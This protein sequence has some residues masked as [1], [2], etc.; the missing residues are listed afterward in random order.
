MRELDL[1]KFENLDRVDRERWSIAASEALIK[2]QEPRVLKAI[3][4]GGLDKFI[5]IAR[6][7]Y[8]GHAFKYEDYKRMFER[9][10]QAAAGLH[11][12]LGTKQR[13][14]RRVH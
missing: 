2:S 9:I 8:D 14:R 13:K 11:E 1:T 5:S 12:D 7:E 10:C 4:A 6:K 3:S